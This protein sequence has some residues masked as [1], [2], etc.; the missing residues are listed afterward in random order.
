MRA[1]VLSAGQGR[2]LLPLTQNDPK[3]LL[4]V[5]GDKPA[6][7]IQLNTL[8]AC[9]VTDVTVLVGFGADRVESFLARTRIRGLA[10]ETLYNPFYSTTDNLVT[11]WLARHCMSEDFLL[12]NGDTL[13]EEALMR[14]VIHGSSAPVTVTVDR[15]T[16]YDDDD[17]KVSLD[18]KGQLLAIGKKLPAATVNAESIGILAFRDV[19]VKWYR[20]ALEATIRRPDALHAWYLSVVNELAQRLPVS[21]AM[22]HGLWWQEIDSVE[23]LNLARDA[24]SDPTSLTAP[25]PNAR[26]SAGADS[27]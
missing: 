17:M 26:V 5:D 13:F 4:P 23:D 8:A 14:Q 21:T 6:L 9:G 22:I 27:L 19:G 10:V 15:K 12:L 20:E 1:I 18:E 7:E 3:C 2:R 24:Y 25:P 16:E 11:C